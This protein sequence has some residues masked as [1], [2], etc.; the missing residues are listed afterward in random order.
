MRIGFDI[1]GVLVNTTAS[2]NNYL[3]KKYGAS[4]RTY[5]LDYI[6]MYEKDSYAN[7][8]PSDI[9]ED[10]SHFFWSAD[11]INNPVIR[12][13]VCNTIR[14]L[15]SI[16]EKGMDKVDKMIVGIMVNKARSIN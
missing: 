9:L 7:I 15:S 4:P 11:F 3:M 1:D 12:R 13:D 16:S 14:N 10:L 6:N 2:L 5:G 8:I